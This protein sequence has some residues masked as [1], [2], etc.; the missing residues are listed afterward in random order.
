MRVEGLL[1]EKKKLERVWVGLSNGA[2]CTQDT[3]KDNR[4]R[5]RCLNLA[6]QLAVCMCIK[7]YINDKEVCQ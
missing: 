6:A 5:R 4:L 7:C 2:V 3:N 1:K